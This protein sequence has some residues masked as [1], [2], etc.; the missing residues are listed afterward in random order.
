MRTLAIAAVWMLAIML[1]GCAVDPGQSDASSRSEAL[2]SDSQSSKLMSCSREATD[3]NL[4]GDM[5]RLYI[6]SCSR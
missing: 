6:E 3:K 2:K 5:R 1:S 4:T